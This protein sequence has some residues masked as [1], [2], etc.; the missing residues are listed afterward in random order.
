MLTRLSLIA[1]MT[2]TVACATTPGSL[3]LMPEPTFIEVETAAPPPA[4]ASPPVADLGPPAPS[5][6]RFNPQLRDVVYTEPGELPQLYVGTLALPLRATDVRAELR[7][8]AAEVTVK[9][10]FVN[11]GET[12]LEAIYSFPLPENSAVTDMRMTIG[13]RVIASEIRERSEARQI[14]NEARDTGHAAALLEQERPNI[15]TQSVANIPR[16]AAIEVEIRYAQ[17]LSYDAGEYEFVFPTVVG[18]RYIPGGGRVPDAA[19][20][21]PP[22]LGHG[23]RSGHDIAIEVV[24]E[25]GSP[26]REWAVPSHQVEALP[27]GDRLHV[28]LARRDEIANR[29]FVLRY[30]SATRQPAARM[31][32]GPADARGGHF[33]LV[34]EPPRLDVDALVGSR[35]LIFVLDV[36]GSMQGTP[37]TLAKAAV[38]E[39]LAG[40]RPVDTF[41]VIVFSGRSARLFDAPRPANAANLR[42]AIDFVDGLRAGGGTEMADA[43]QAALG[44]PVAP[45]RHRYVAFFT[46][47]Y[48]GEE[49]A[50][51]RGARELVARLG[52]ADR[53]A[54]VFGVGV[55]SAPNAHLIAELAQAGDGLP[56]YI[57]TP[58]DVTRAIA[59]Y[60]GKIDSPVLTHLGI[61]WTG[62]RVTDVS[63][64]QLPDLFASRPLVIHGRYDE[65]APRE[66]KLIATRAGKRVSIPIAVTTLATRDDRLGPLWARA[67]VDDLDLVRVTATSPD[68]ATQAIAQI[69][70]LGL[71]HRLV[72]AYTSL[73]A[74]DTLK[75]QPAPQTTVVQPVEGPAGAT[76]FANSTPGARVKMSEVRDIPLGGTSRDFTA[77]VD[78]S[79]TVRNDSAGVRLAGT[80]GAESKHVD[81]TSA[82]APERLRMAITADRTGGV[83]RDFAAVSEHTYASGDLD[84]TPGPPH[85]RSLGVTPHARP[86]VHA[87]RAL[88]G[89]P[90]LRLARAQIDAALPQ[91]GQCF[92]DARAATYRVRRKLALTLQLGADGRVTL[93]RVRGPGTGDR[94]LA[95]CLE[96][97]LGVLT[98]TTTARLQLELVVWMQY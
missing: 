92:V 30:R 2:W 88:R 43:V 36:S 25:A 82:E 64:Q 1:G 17:T 33:M 48:T 50:I 78:L 61:D 95:T 20:I 66:L 59:S 6:G 15:F 34:V 73:V 58:T 54:R 7:A 85:Q 84:H 72:T 94:E 98:G 55:G 86:R 18:P 14:Y 79:P 32:L 60:Q 56:L 57:H 41:D 68:E 26:I 75:Q 39:A 90:D 93:L 76:H 87:L 40:M 19:R 27:A 37:L 3:L 51:A 49:E 52:R 44:S 80:S 12:A 11:D 65:Q 74:V 4:A 8:D 31:F 9:Q 22:L 77:V 46:D 89:A 42:H 23:L 97:Q 10:R 83:S 69:R 5:E 24:A 81:G 96:R 71:R 67:R 70:E 62:L 47:G 35:E 38:R 28:K 13:D 29:D 16:G 45:G 91:L 53:R 21:S 63:P